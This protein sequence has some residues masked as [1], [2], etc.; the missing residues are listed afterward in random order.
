MKKIIVLGGGYGGVLT[1][2]K[3][4][5]K[6]KKDSNVEITLID[7]LPYHT[8]LTELHEVAAYRTDEDAVKVD[9]KKIFAGKKVDVVMDEITNINFAEKTLHS[10]TASY[11]YDY[12][13]I[14]TGCKPTFF[15]IPGA[16]ENSFT[17]WSHED[18]VRLKQQFRTMF[19]EAAKTADKQKRAD[20]LSFVVVGAGFTGVEMVGE[21]AEYRDDL[22]KEFYLDPAE[23]KI[24]SVD[25]APK[26][27][28]ILPDSLIAKAEK[29][30]E[31]LGIEIITG[32]KIEAVKENAVV[33]GGRGELVANTIIWTAGVEGSELLEN[34]DLEQK[35]RKRIVTNDKLQS[36]DHENVYVIGDNIF[37]I[38]EGEER[39]VP[40]MVENTEHSAPLVAHNIHATITGSQLK[41]YKPLFHG[42]MVCIGSRYGV[43]NVGTP[44]KMF[45]FSGFIAMFMKH[46]INMVYLVQVAGFNKVWN[47]MLH[48]FFHVKNRRSFVGGHFSKRSPNFWLV[49]LRIYVGIMW[50]LEGWEKLQ[51][52]QEDPGRIFLI[53]PAPTADATTAAT[54]A[55]DAVNQTVDAQTAASAVSNASDAIKALPVPDFVTSMVKGSMNLMFYTNDGGYTWLAHAF[56]TGMICAEII[57]GFL[58]IVGLFTAFS[59]IA[60]VG[61]GA[62]IW[63]SGMAPPEMLW[64]M[65]AGIALIGGSGSTFGL[66]YYVLPKLKKAWKKIP[67]VKRW[68]IYTD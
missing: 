8:L 30:M 62:M 63:A 45:K 23:V 27:L 15:G 53:P 33:L 26:I 16:E 28:P 40:Q 29:R 65:T 38:P 24:Y 10:E 47:Y 20:M 11:T 3:L 42:A 46:M 5:K 59:S 44:K 52:I 35:G 50:L 68:Y 31:K 55:I 18:A 12:L 17:L 60:T 21:L 43:A 41:T 2:K 13:V 37:F 14:G 1:A 36:V 67:F 25:M 34:L 51:K 64:Y 57:F 22:C 58:L 9:L 39:P 4:A 56:Q 49:P 7:K 6:F 48:E 54:Q 66:D 32:T 19:S 61:M